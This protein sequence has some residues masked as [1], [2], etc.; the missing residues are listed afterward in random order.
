MAC[1]ASSMSSS[2][3]NLQGNMKPARIKDQQLLSRTCIQPTDLILIRVRTPHSRH[4]SMSHTVS[5]VFSAFTDLFLVLIGSLVLLIAF[6]NIIV[7]MILCRLVYYSIGK[8]LFF[9]SSLF[10]FCKN[11][12]TTKTTDARA[13]R[14]QKSHDEQRSPIIRDHN[15]IGYLG[16]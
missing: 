16:L 15:R 5:S 7:I 10:Q 6:I 3:M 8:S 1:Q 4:V 9:E 14:I 2:R 12:K 11:F 13:K